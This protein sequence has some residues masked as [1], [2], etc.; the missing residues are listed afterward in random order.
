MQ[1]NPF[2]TLFSNCMRIC[3]YMLCCMHCLYGME[4][5]FVWRVSCYKLHHYT[6]E[7]CLASFQC[8]LPDPTLIYMLQYTITAEKHYYCVHTTMENGYVNHF[9]D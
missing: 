9:P 2:T 5:M 3:T 1:R 8:T 4:I 6:S 7:Y